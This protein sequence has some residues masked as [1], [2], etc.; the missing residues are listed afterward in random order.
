MA[1]KTEKTIKIM[2][3]LAFTIVLSMIYLHTYQINRHFDDNYY[4]EWPSDSGNYYTFDLPEEEQKK[5][6]FW[7][8]SCA[9]EDGLSGADVDFTCAHTKMFPFRG[10]KKFHPSLHEV[11]GEERKNLVK[12][13]QE[14]K[15]RNTWIWA[16]CLPLIGL[17]LG[18]WVYLY[19]FNNEQWKRTP[20]AR[21]LLFLG[22]V[23]CD[24][25]RDKRE[26]NED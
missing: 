5:V 7:R 25:D 17:L 4:I 11:T 2:A 18:Y 24:E 3:F 13:I 26:G 8:W 12:R 20:L 6:F 1:T 21:L 10:E 22:K 16:I 15:L 23:M 19:Q 14:T 9:I